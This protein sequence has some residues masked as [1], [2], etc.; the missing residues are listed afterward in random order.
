VA[1][2][3]NFSLY[4]LRHERLDYWDP[5]I[6]LI[7]LLAGI[8]SLVVVSL[9]TP[10]ER[11]TQVDT[12][13]TNLETPSDLGLEKAEGQSLATPAAQEGSPSVPASA[14]ELGRWAAERGRQLLFVNLLHLRRGTYGV[15]FFQAYRDD[16]KGL[17][18]GSALSVGIV[19]F[20]W[21]ILQL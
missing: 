12:F 9:L 15:S 6:F 13:F 17:V 8:L 5:N 1:L 10:A 4:H 21:L 11:G 20:M 2:L 3:V 19:F 16:L 7:S 14:A 18:M